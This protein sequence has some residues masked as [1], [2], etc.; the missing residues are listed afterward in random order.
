[1]NVQPVT[2]MYETE[3]AVKLLHHQKRPDAVFERYYSYPKDSF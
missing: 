2:D 1:M 3:H